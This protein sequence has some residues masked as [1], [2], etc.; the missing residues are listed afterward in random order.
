[1][2]YNNVKPKDSGL[3]RAFNTDAD[4]A[5]FSSTV[6][7]TSTVTVTY[8]RRWL[9]W[10]RRTFRWLRPCFE[11]PSPMVQGGSPCSKSRP[12]LRGMSEITNEQKILKWN[13]ETYWHLKF[14][15]L[16]LLDK[17]KLYFKYYIL[18]DIFLYSKILS[19]LSWL[20]TLFVFKI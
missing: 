15:F 12:P 3:Q 10:L 2:D 7:V 17:Q 19:F 6:E 16:M 18:K 4:K 20:F 1:M 8:L 5:A 14:E 13:Y 9:L 11:I